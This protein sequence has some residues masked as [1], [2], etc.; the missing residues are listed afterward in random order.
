[1]GAAIKI[2]VSLPAAIHRHFW[3]RPLA[4]LSL[5][6]NF[7]GNFPYAMQGINICI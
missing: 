7:F 4:V 1:M 3:K 6:F 5:E 2:V